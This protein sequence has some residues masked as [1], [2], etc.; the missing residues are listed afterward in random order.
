MKKNT[1][2]GMAVFAFLLALPVLGA[3]RV[4][5]GGID[6]WRTRGDGSTFTEINFPA[7]FFC[8]DSGPFKGRI[9]FQGV[10]IATGIPGQL[11]TTDTIVHR[12]DDAVFNK[13]GVAYTRVQVR[14]MT[15]ES[16]APLKTA[17]GDFNST[18]ALDGLQPITRMTILQ[19]NRNGGRFVAQIG[20]N[21]KIAF[22][23]VDRPAE[24]PLEI[25]RKIRFQ[26]NAR[27][28]WS[29]KPSRDTIL[30]AAPVLVDTNGDQI[31]DTYLPGTTRNFAAGTPRG[32]Q[33]IVFC[34]RS[35]DCTHCPN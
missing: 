2:I 30:H 8:A 32:L 11:E 4:I 3:D 24:R 31:A 5:P 22:T 16:V 33:K 9:A 20:V 29:F 21:I 6:P 25:R 26:E 15:F 1:A 35:D 28:P 23:P 19:E 12:L 7:G 14:A 17:C 10:P 18:V 27:L 34:H 13:K